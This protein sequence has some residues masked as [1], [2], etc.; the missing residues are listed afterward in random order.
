[1][2]MRITDIVHGMVPQEPDPDEQP[3]ELVELDDSIHT[4][5]PTTLKGS[6]KT[7]RVWTGDEDELSLAEACLP[8]HTLRWYRQQIENIDRALGNVD[9]KRDVLLI[10]AIQRGFG[11]SE[12]DQES[13]EERVARII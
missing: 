13:D 12:D 4:V 5:R 8:K 2:R 1:M 10:Q 9:Q 11:K 7:L 6:T 3:V